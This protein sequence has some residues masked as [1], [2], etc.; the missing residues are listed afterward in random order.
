MIKIV[1]KTSSKDRDLAARIT[2]G[3][4]D[5]LTEHQIAREPDIKSKI[6]TIYQPNE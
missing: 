2:E 3:I 6:T 1:V 4:K 5:T